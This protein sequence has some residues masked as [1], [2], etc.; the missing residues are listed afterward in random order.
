MPVRQKNNWARIA[1][2]VSIV[3]SLFGVVTVIYN[4][5][6]TNRE[7]IQKAAIDKILYRGEM[8]RFKDSVRRSFRRLEKVDSLEPSF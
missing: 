3:I 6:E 7:A 5:T 4:K 8:A 1:S 2:I